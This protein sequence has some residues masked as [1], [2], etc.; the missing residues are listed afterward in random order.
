MQAQEESAKR[1]FDSSEDP[2]VGRS[3]LHL[4]ILLHERPAVVLMSGNAMETKLCI[5]CDHW[6]PVQR[7]PRRL[8]RPVKRC[9]QNLAPRN[10]TLLWT[11]RNSWSVYAS[12]LCSAGCEHTG[13]DQTAASEEVPRSRP[14]FT[15]QPGFRRIEVLF[16]NHSISGWCSEANV[17]APNP[18]NLD[19]FAWLSMR[20]DRTLQGPPAPCTAERVPPLDRA[21]ASAM[22]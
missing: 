1:K 14:N 13:G 19:P 12:F 17:G 9:P 5:K 10:M 15:D 11:R 20:Q 6:V 3:P 16:S 8:Q 2:A 4:I 7:H 22:L 18:R 21:P